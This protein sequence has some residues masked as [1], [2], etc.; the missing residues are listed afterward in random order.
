MLGVCLLYVGIV[1]INNGICR[2]SN[3]DSK[4]TAVMNIFTG[5]L[6][7]I[8]NVISLVYGDYYSAGTGLLFGFTYLFV[9]I[10]GIFKLDSRPFG[11]Y[12]LF[13]AINAVFF[14]IISY[15]QGDW[16]FSIIWLLWAILWFTGFIESILKK[17]LGKSVPM[18]QIFEGIVTAW[19]PGLLMLTNMW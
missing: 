1:L 7:I 2:L 13:V 19:I 6:S 3:I 14:A 4:S 15:I 17:N 9:A 12:S 8:I 10:N 11:W 18:L 5:T 16:R